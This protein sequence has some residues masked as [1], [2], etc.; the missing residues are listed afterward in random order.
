M[1][2]PNGF[3]SGQAEC[4]LATVY[5]RSYSAAREQRRRETGADPQPHC[6][7]RCDR[8]PRPVGGSADCRQQDPVRRADRGADPSRTARFRREPCAGSSGQM[9]AV[10]RPLPRRP[11]ARHWPASV[12]QG[13]RCTAAFHYHSFDRSGTALG[14]PCEGSRAG[15][16]ARRRSTSRSTSVGKSRRAAAPFRKPVTWS[17][18]FGHRHS[19]SSGSWRSLRS[20]WSPRPISRFLAKLARRHDVNGLSIGMSSDFEAAVM[21]GATAVRVGTALFEDE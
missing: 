2:S 18:R 9:A 10:A 5:R 11:P 7:R 17:R 15:Q 3:A 6:A 19:N 1:S 21:L 4:G 8:K 16:G 14:Y 20:A 12:E 13:C